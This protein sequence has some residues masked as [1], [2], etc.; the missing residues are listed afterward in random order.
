MRTVVLVVSCLVVVD[1]VRE[2][3]KAWAIS[4]PHVFP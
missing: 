1:F 4:D 3:P 2:G